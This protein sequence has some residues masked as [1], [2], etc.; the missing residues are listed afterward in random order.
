MANVVLPLQHHQCGC[1]RDILCS[2]PAAHTLLQPPSLP[3]VR[4]PLLLQ[5]VYDTL[6]LPTTVQPKHDDRAP[7][8][9]KPFP[10]DYFAR[11]SV[12]LETAN[13]WRE[14]AGALEECG[15]PASKV[16]LLGCIIV[17][18]GLLG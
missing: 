14:A 15:A 17:A 18:A 10:A 9:L 4:S 5:Y 8:Q 6:H 1:L 11:R 16:G 2:H 13:A 7:P 12:I 3:S